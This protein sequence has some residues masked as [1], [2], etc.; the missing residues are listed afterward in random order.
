LT[1]LVN[2]SKNEDI[3]FMTTI[4]GDSLGNN[5]NGTYI[6]DLIYGREGDD[7]LFGGNGDDSL[8]GEDGN[9][10]LFGEDGNDRLFG[11]NGNDR[12]DGGRGNDL[13][14]SGNG[15]D[16]LIGG[17]GRN[18]LNGAGEYMGNDGRGDVDILIG[19]G[20]D[21]EAEGSRI[22]PYENTFIVDAP[23]GYD[24]YYYD[25]RDSSS[26]GENDYARIIDFSVSFDKIQLKKVGASHQYILKDISA[27]SPLNGGINASMDTGIYR[28][29]LLFG[30]GV[31]E[32]IG[33]VQDVSGLNLNSAYFTYV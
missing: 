27:T 6:G 31:D 18:I 28:Q 8:Y 11:G 19:G 2:S 21:E 20:V 17:I 30:A 22:R 15:S 33:V 25:D 7:R 1:D 4:F 3:E 23:S 12:L 9:D 5:I 10:S 29:N 26:S 13:L 14:Y 32:L 16:T 24:G